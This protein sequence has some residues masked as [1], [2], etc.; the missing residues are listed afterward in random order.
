MVN[1]R[2]KSSKDSQPQSL[3][4][5]QCNLESMNMVRTFCRVVVCYRPISAISYPQD[6]NERP[7]FEKFVVTMH[8]GTCKT[9]SEIPRSIG[10][11]I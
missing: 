6:L 7:A 1:P 11:G 3:M 5:T 4:I 2:H 8:E 9:G 10:R